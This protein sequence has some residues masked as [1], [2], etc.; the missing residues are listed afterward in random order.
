MYV[1][2]AARAPS[3]TSTNPQFAAANVRVITDH[4]QVVHHQL[5]ALVEH[6][7]ITK[8]MLRPD[9]AVGSAAA[10]ASSMG[11]YGGYG[12]AAAGGYGGGYGGGYDGGYGGGY[13]GANA[14][15]S[16]PK[17]TALLDL[18][19]ANQGEMGFDLRT[20]IP[21][22]RAAA[23]PIAG[24]MTSADVENIIAKLNS[25]GA[26]YAGADPNHVFCA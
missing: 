24:S 17:T 14:S 6:L 26:V 21:M 22:L 2:V 15:G 16:D 23:H 10:S 13:G 11:G 12:G 9:G 25:E 5:Q 7:Q 4:N 8:G 3:S 1:D 19:R 20:A 18:I